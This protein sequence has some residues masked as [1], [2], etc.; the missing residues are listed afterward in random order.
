MARVP[1]ADLAVVEIRKLADYCLDPAH[2]RGRHKARVFREAL[3]LGQN[4]ASWLRDVLLD[5]LRH[6][7]AAELAGDGFGRRWRVDVA[8]ARHG[9]RGVVRT[10]WIVR[11]GEQA[12]R[13]VTC[14]VL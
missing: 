4:D 5:G 11:S 13:F 7:E 14:W 1:N 2:P 10:I 6:G 9:K 3:G 8:V 12:P